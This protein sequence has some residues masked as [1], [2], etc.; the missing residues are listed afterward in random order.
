MKALEPFVQATTTEMKK[1]IKQ[2]SQVIVLPP[3]GETST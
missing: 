2:I 1:N 3:L